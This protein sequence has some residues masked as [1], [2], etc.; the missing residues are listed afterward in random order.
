MI[1]RKCREGN[2]DLRRFSVWKVCGLRVRKTQRSV[3]PIVSC[4][5]FAGKRIISTNHED[6]LIPSIG[7]S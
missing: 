1:F 7:R 2:D 3:T 4:L 6:G 5:K